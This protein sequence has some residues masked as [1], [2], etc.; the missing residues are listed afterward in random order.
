[1]KFIDPRIDFAFK[2]IFGS[3][4][5]K[6]I[7]ISFLESLLG[8]EGERRIAELTILDPFLAPRIRELKSSVLDVRCKD[9]RGISYIV[10]MQI[11]KVA[12]FLKRI[13]YNSAKAYSQQIARGVDYPRLKQVIAITITDFVLFEEFTHCVSTH[14]SR[15]TVTGKPY[16]LDIV[17]YFV[18][19]PKFSKDLDHC[20]TVFDQWL[21]FLK[22]AERIE[23]IPDQMGLPPIRHAFEKAKIAN[24]TPDELELYDKAG[25]AVADARGRVELAWE[26]GQSKGRLEGRLEGLQEGRL[27]G[28][29]EGERKGK[30]HILLQWLQK[31]FGALPEALRDR[32]DSA[33]P[34]D[35]ER[36]S[37]RIFDAR[38]LQEIFDP[39][40]HQTG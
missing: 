28:L 14:E 7:L 1:M 39:D 17:Y 11:E 22:N 20:E 31:R 19:L 24:M 25:I 10:E 33:Q 30:I 23:E 36:W 26:E 40:D 34:P 27:E 38:T 4:D 37:E 8:L 5:A 18:E 6:D 2:K 16:L 35:L 3:E 13:Q 29:Q 12:A 9:H 15:E 21:Y 32:I